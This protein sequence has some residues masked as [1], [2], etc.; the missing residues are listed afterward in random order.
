[1]NNNF[2]ITPENAAKSVKNVSKLM[3]CDYEGA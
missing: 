3:G 1:M 2:E